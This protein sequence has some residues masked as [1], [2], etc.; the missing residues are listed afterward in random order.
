MFSIQMVYVWD[1]GYPNYPDL[2]ITQYLHVLTYVPYKY[3]QLLFIKK[4]TLKKDCRRDGL[5]INSAGADLD[6]WVMIKRQVYSLYKLGWQC[7][8]G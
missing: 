4:V 5:E 1:D 6:S 8:E 7:L 2:I 3:V